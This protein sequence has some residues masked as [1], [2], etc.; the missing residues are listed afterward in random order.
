MFAHTPT[1]ASATHTPTPHHVDTTSDR[2]RL[3]SLIQ[4]LQRKVRFD[5]RTKS[6]WEGQE[7]LYF[8]DS[9]KLLFTCFGC[10]PD[11]A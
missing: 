1:I 3:K 8:S 4:V 7:R 9:S 10:F 11:G 2:L 6:I 5:T